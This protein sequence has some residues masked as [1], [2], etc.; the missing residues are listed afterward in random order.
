VFRRS[1]GTLVAALDCEGERH[2]VRIDADGTVPLAG[3]DLAA[4]P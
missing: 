4:L 2:Q 1:G 3:H